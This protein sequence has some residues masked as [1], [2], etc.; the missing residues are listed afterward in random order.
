MVPVDA[1]WLAVDT[2]GKA[3]PVEDRNISAIGQ[4]ACFPAPLTTTLSSSYDSNSGALSATYTRT[5][6]VT[7]AQAA[8]GYAAIPN[9]LVQV[10]AAV[11]GGPRPAGPCAMTQQQHYGAF[12][13]VSINFQAA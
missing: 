1:V 12:G 11:G 2:T 10:V 4:P 7:P 6:A 8:L 3:L 9:A 13:D 5:L